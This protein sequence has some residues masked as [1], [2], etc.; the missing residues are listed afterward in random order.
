MLTIPLPRTGTLTCRDRSLTFGSR[1][2]IMGI[3]NLTPDSFSGDGLAGSVDRAV[4]LARTMAEEG[5]DLLDVG[6]ESTRPDAQRISV[7]EEIRRIVPSIRAIL[8]AVDVPISV[9]TR[10]STVAEAAL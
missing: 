8:E 7:E 10:R 9:D 4:E 5:A 2:L 6:G 3:I 1:T